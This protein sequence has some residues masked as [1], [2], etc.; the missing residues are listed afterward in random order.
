MKKIALS[1]IF[2]TA[3]LLT[4]C[5]GNQASEGTTSPAETI[6]ATPTDQ[7]TESPT[8]A[9]TATPAASEAA[10]DSKKVVETYARVDD[11]TE[12]TLYS[13][14]TATVNVDPGLEIW[15]DYADPNATGEEG[16]EGR[17]RETTRENMA[18]EREIPSEGLRITDVYL[19]Q[20]S[21]SIPGEEAYAAIR[22]EGDVYYYIDLVGFDTSGE[23][24]VILQEFDSIR[25]KDI[26][27]IAFR[28]DTQTEGAHAL[29]GNDYL[30][31]IFEDS[32]EELIYAR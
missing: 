22:C 7:E 23:A 13:D 2:L 32:S 30:Y 26:K 5:N 20:S 9:Q 24:P 3:L 25:G 8:A 12:I 18:L 31:A 14:G 17:F 15:T 19:F 28:T 4:A 16:E 10:T 1:A 21:P 11:A 27:T 29:I 6:A